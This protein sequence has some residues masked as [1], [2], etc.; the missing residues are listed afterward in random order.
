[1]IELRPFASIGRFRNDWL[2]AHH[3]FSFGHY[4]DPKRMGFGSLVV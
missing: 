2:N 1:M 4:R 3:H